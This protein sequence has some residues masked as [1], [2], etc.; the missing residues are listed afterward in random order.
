MT[1]DEA[2][3]ILYEIS[4]GSQSSPIG[5]DLVSDSYEISNGFEPLDRGDAA[6]YADGDSF[7][8]VREF[9]A[10]TDPNEPSS[11]PTVRATPWLYRLLLSD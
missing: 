10:G 3:E 9:R 5:L 11:F 4:L 8:N 6:E 7:S 2:K 1:E